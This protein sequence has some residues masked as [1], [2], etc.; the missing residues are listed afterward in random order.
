ML[1]QLLQQSLVTDITILT[2]YRGADVHLTVRKFYGKSIMKSRLYFLDFPETTGTLSR[3]ASALSYLETEYGYCVCGIDS[4]ISVVAFEQF[5]SYVNTHQDDAILTLSPRIDVAFTH[6]LARINGD[7]IKCYVARGYLNERSLELQW[8]T[9]VGIRY[10]PAD[11]MSMLEDI[12]ST[13]TQYIPS[14]IQG[15]LSVGIIVKG[16]VFEDKWSHFVTPED[17]KNLIPLA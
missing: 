14:F 15:L 12:E 5:C 16:F 10:F 3:L 7:E 2:G 4:L 13:Q 17:L 6:K 1:N 8:F 11:I 9:D